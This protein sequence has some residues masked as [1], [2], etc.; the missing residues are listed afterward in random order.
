MRSTL[1]FLG[2]TPI[3][4]G[5]SS[6]MMKTIMCRGREVKFK[7]GQAVYDYGREVRCVY[8]IL[9]GSVVM[10][11]RQMDVETA[12]Y[13]LKEEKG[14]GE[15]ESENPVLLPRGGK[16]VPGKREKMNRNYVDV[17]V[18]DE[19]HSVGEKY[20][21]GKMKAEERAA[22]ASENTVLIEINIIELNKVLV[23][24]DKERFKMN[25][26]K[27]CSNFQKIYESVVEVKSRVKGSFQ[28]DQEASRLAR[29]K[30]EIENDMIF[31]RKSKKQIVRLTQDC[32]NLHNEKM[33]ADRDYVK[34]RFTVLNAI[35]K[36]IAISSS[37]AGREGNTCKNSKETTTK[38]P[39]LQLQLPT[40]E[41]LLM[42]SHLNAHQLGKTASS[43]F[44]TR[45]N[46][47]V[48]TKEKR[49]L[50]PEV[51]NTRDY[52]AHY[53]QGRQELDYLTDENIGLRSISV[54]M[55]SKVKTACRSP[56]RKGQHYHTD[57]LMVGPIIR[58]CKSGT[59][60]KED[61]STK[62]NQS[63]MREESPSN[64]REHDLRKSSYEV[65]PMRESI[66]SHPNR[67]LLHSASS[68]RKTS[69]SSNM[70]YKLRQS[71]FSGKNR[72]TRYEHS[73]KEPVVIR[74][75]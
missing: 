62:P 25:C 70:M 33:K 57:S 66:D 65:R 58:S 53:D 15:E 6:G 43:F 11:A 74:L 48:H 2:S 39:G 41:N 30:Q 35:S 10:Q 9:K 69:L 23:D 73:Y 12:G 52:I 44:I 8:I 31:I 64:K 38:N 60:K 29:K 45:K 21:K 3:L 51:D 55:L 19:R 72:K 22:A 27:V 1:D 14:Q 26:E 75:G 16:R 20:I 4:R 54:K 24:K 59:L 50:E 68:S 32:L 47:A 18:R 28:N 17:C 36:S 42:E 5:I 46:S 7:F 63:I 40:K 61:T 37:F 34:N 67:W 71:S 13:C 56:K 49:K